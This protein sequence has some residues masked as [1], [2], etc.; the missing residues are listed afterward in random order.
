M[1]SYL[2]AHRRLFSVVVYG[3]SYLVLYLVLLGLLIITPAD[4]IE[5]SLRNRQNYNIWILTAGYVLTI[6]VVAFVFF[7]RLFLNQSELSSI[8]KSWV[9]VEKGDVPSRVHKLIGERLGRSANIAYEA[10]P[11]LK[12]GD[13]EEDEAERSRAKLLLD[14]SRSEETAI[15]LPPRDAVWGDIEHYGWASPNSPDLPNLHYSTVFSELPN[16]IEGKAMTLAPP[17]PTSEA[18]PPLLDPDAVALLQRTANMDLRDYMVHLADL[19]VLDMDLTTTQFLTQYEHAR[20]STR[21]ISNARFKELMHLFAE[22]LRAMEPFNPDI[23][24]GGEGSELTSSESQVDYEARINPSLKS[25]SSMQSISDIGS[26]SSSLRQ[27]KRDSSTSWY[28]WRTAPQSLRSRMTGATGATGAVSR[29]SSRHSFTHSRRRHPISVQPSS[30]SLRS[31]ASAS[32]GSV[33]RLATRHDTSDLP[34]ILSMRDTAGS[35]FIP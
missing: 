16:L 24:D 26:I 17:D 34:Y 28:H 6:V 1:A 31:L 29:K 33:I 13:E 7:T 15:L 9:P 22:I 12:L 5:R 35:Q 8:P 2:P 11:R 30:R 32:S 19:G 20:F 27:R 14:Y 3:S 10:R 25:E 23:L 18:D 21:P 4:A